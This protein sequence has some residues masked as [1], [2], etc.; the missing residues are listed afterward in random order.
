MSTKRPILVHKNTFLY[1]KIP[2][3]KLR[4]DLIFNE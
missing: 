4:R 2:T 1:V 3:E